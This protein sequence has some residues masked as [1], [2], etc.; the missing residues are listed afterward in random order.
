MRVSVVLA[1]GNFITFERGENRAE[2]VAV[3]GESISAVGRIDEVRQL[4]GPDTRWIDCRG[5]TVLPGFHDAHFHIMASIT[6]KLDLDC[7]P[8]AVK[9]IADIERLVRNQAGLI[10][11]GDWIIGSGYDEHYLREKRHPT[12]RDL[13]RASPVNPVRLA[14]RSGHAYV[15]NSMA[16]RLAG[17]R[18][19]VD[20]PDGV[21]IDR[22]PETGEPNGIMLGRGG[23]WEGNVIPKPSGDEIQSGC[24]KLDH[25]LFSCGITSV[26]DAG[27]D[28]GISEWEQLNRLVESGHLGGR[29]TMMAGIDKAELC[30]AHGIPGPVKLGPVKVMLDETRGYLNPPLQTL[31]EK[32]RRYYLEGVPLAI[33]AVEGGQLDGALEL[34]E[35]LKIDYGQ[36][37]A[38]N[39]IEH[40]SVAHPEILDR[41]LKTGVAVVTHPGFIYYQG[42]RYLETV[43]RDDLPWLYAM[44]SMEKKGLLVAAGS[45][46]PIAPPDPLRGIAAAVNR[47]TKLGAHIGLEQAIKV[48][49]AI[50]AYTINAAQVGG[51]E[52]RTG[53][54]EVGKDADLVIIGGNI[55]DT[56]REGSEGLRVLLTMARG[57]IVQEAGAL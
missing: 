31:I 57:R 52:D 10:K 13:D 24:R 4:A 32:T 30:L 40:C 39:R 23:W 11:N 5:M 14:H 3:S 47:R 53:S 46:A 19:D 18:I 1:G 38:L 8:D 29:V 35:I 42:D 43:H 12:R 16:L 36:P 20:E 51:L 37:K 28:N 56:S 50:A 55:E 22:E 33:H 26:Q 21:I 44:A 9:S 17:I 34:L 48:N 7:G 41:M 25:E 45:D 6:R 27:A 54:I 15:L 49:Q 2:A